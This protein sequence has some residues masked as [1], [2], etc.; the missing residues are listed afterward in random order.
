MERSK[1]EKE[2]RPRIIE[3]AERMENAESAEEMRELVSSF[4]EELMGLDIEL[5]PD[6]TALYQEMEERHDL[7]RLEQIKKVMEAVL[8]RKPIAI[9]GGEDHYANAVVPDNEGLKIALSEGEAPGPVRLLVG[10]DIKSAI[11]FNP[12]G[13][14]VSDIEQSEMDIRNQNIRAALCRH[15]SGEL[16]PEAIEYLIMRVPRH[17]FPDKLL[18]AE[19]SKSKTGFVFRGSRI[20]TF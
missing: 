14:E 15:V 6:V 9:G 10:F 18:T 1:S 7:V 4:F 11:A 20:K 19:E 2:P 17:L 13:L 16:K 12:A 5:T 3:V 8:E